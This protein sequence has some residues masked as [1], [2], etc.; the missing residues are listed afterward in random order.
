MLYDI[1]TSCIIMYH[2]WKVDTFCT[3]L[4]KRALCY[5]LIL[6]KEYLDLL[7]KVIIVAFLMERVLK[8]EQDIPTTIVNL[9]IS[10]R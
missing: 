10:Q 3:I 5:A 7:Q 2:V 6:I 1:I 8:K 9:C 4:F